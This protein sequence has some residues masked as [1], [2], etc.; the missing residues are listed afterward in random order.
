MLSDGWQ[1]NAGLPKI[2]SLSILRLL[3]MQHHHKRQ[4]LKQFLVTQRILINY[5]QGYSFS[6][7]F[8]YFYPVSSFDSIYY[9]YQPDSLLYS[10]INFSQRYNVSIIWDSQPISIQRSPLLEITPRCQ[11]AYYPLNYY[12]TKGYCCFED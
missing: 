11:Q 8:H 5:H 3:L 4:L 6:N 2:D 10:A 1:M 12:K 7:S 9:D